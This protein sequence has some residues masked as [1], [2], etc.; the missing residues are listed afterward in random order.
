[1][2]LSKL[3]FLLVTVTCIG[4]QHYPVVPETWLLSFMLHKKLWMT[5][6]KK[7]GTNPPEAIS[8]RIK[9]WAYNFKKIM[10]TR[11]PYDKS[12]SHEKVSDLT[13]TTD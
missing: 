11:E 10:F 3:V 13:M 8:D 1:M 2:I 4:W 6:R 9:K 7:R 12:Y 5:Q